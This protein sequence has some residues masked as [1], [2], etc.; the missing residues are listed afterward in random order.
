VAEGFDPARCQLRKLL[1]AEPGSDVQI[2]VLAVLPERACFEAISLRALD[3]SVGGLRNGAALAWGGMDA[4]AN[5]H[6]DRSVIG[7]G[8]F[9]FFKG[10]DVSITVLIDVIDN[11][12]L[13]LFA[14]A[15]NPFSLAYRHDGPPSLW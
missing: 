12:S 9:L 13:P 1:P 4:L 15:R 7:V 6:L 14:L 3:P 8:I 2:D 10:A 5:V 11:P